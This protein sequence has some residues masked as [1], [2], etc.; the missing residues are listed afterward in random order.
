MRDCAQLFRFASSLVLCAFALPG[1]TLGCDGGGD[2]TGGSGGGTG[3]SG[4]STVD[5]DCTAA[6]S[7]SA[8]D[9]ST[10][11]T[12]LIEAKEGDILC[13]TEGTFKFN[14]ELSLDVNKVTLRGKGQDATIWDF[15]AQDVGAN[16]VL[17][18]S[19]NVTVEKLTVKNTPGD[20]LRADSVENITF[21][22]M[23]VLWEADASLDN[24]AYGLY[25]VGSTGV[26][27]DTC[28]V[29]GARDAGIYVG[30]S[31][32]IVVTNSEAYGNVAG[33]EI[34]NSTD[35]EVMNNKAH[36]NTAGILVF[37]LPGLPVQDGKRAKVHDNIIQNN[38]IPNFGEPGTTVSQVPYGV[39][40]M[41]LAT[42][43]NEVHNNTI[44]GNSSVGILMVSYLESLFGMPNDPAYNSFPEGN[45]IHDNTFDNNG[46][47]P[48]PLIGD[49][50]GGFSPIPSI[51][52]D[53]CLDP[54]AVDDGHLKNCLNNNMTG[55]GDPASFVNI[56]MCNNPSNVDIDAAKVTCEYEP[57]PPQN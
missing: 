24:G 28:V 56:D 51:V 50:A 9:Q 19:D 13:F 29:K 10:V 35:A 41:L 14:T 11:Q 22:N 43:D 21:R 39:G 34:E 31:T 38:N 1:L 47:D 17:I 5:P 32:N 27:I 20:G 33:I 40:L 2:G 25:P 53:G 6:I 26:L 54:N 37:N 12:A 49:S 4:G 8:D 42:D 16:G 3:G 15:S 18:K 52:W 7:P 57:L 44:K 48:D 36:D 55:A 46:K 23:T 30:Q 45:F